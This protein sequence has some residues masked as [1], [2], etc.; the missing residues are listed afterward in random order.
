[1]TMSRV[2]KRQM[3]DEIISRIDFDKERRRRSLA[4]K[5]DKKGAALPENNRQQRAVAVPSDVSA[6]SQAPEK[7]DITSYT[8]RRTAEFLQ[9]TVDPSQLL[10]EQLELT[11]QREY[12][13]QSY[14]NNI[15]EKATQ[16][17]YGNLVTELKLILDCFL[18]VQQD[19]MFNF[20]LILWTDNEGKAQGLSMDEVNELASAIRYPSKIKIDV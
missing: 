2:Q 20:G 19:S 8:Q 1:M 5:Q 16:N 14:F 11:A 13:E 6:K 18:S 4:Y 9:H 7:E 10:K 17:G 12:K 3:Y 15:C